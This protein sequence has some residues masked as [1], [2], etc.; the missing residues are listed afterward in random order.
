MSSRASIVTKK[1]GVFIDPFVYGVEES[2]RRYVTYGA[3]QWIAQMPVGT[4]RLLTSCKTK[5]ALPLPF[6][7][8]RLGEGVAYKFLPFRYHG[9]SRATQNAVDGVA[10][11]EVRLGDHANEYSWGAPTSCSVFFSIDLPGSSR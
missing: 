8:L 3:A 4:E 6:P 11:H 9:G 10:S 7:R 1:G 5:G 2:L